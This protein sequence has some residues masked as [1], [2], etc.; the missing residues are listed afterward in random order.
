MRTH[1][2]IQ[3]HIQ[4]S[5]HSSMSHNINVAINIV[6]QRESFQVHPMSCAQHKTKNVQLNQDNTFG[7]VGNTENP[8]SIL[9]TRAYTDN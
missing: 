2:H 4:G 3:F 6:N 8:Q 9:A 7:Q 5:K 1:A